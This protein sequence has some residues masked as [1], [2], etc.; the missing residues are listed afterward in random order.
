MLRS[1]RWPLSMVWKLCLPAS[2]KMRRKEMLS[3][4]DLGFIEFRFIVAASVIFL[5]NKATQASS[6][7]LLL[8]K[9]SCFAFKIRNPINIQIVLYLGSK[10][11]CQLTSLKHIYH[12]ANSWS[13]LKILQQSQL[14][15]AINFSLIKNITFKIHTFLIL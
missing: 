6:L 5:S 1:E 2:S 4:F 13:S 7:Y 10:W 12:A 11:I 9:A 8:L 14:D 15:C 3:S